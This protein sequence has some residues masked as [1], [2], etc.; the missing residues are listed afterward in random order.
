MKKFLFL[1]ALAASMGIMTSCSQEDDYAPSSGVDDN[2][3]AFSTKSND[4]MTRSGQTTNSLAKFTVTAVNADKTAHFSSVEF[5]F[6][7]F[8]S[9]FKSATPYY[10]PVGSALSFYAISNPGTVSLDA[11]NVPKYAYTN[12]GG[13]T[14]LV[15]A[16]VLAGNKQTPY[17]LA[18]QH[19]LSQIVISADAVD[20][21]EKLTYKLVDV[22]MTAPCN[23]TYSFASATGG[24]GSWEISNSA[25]KAYSYAS[26]MPKTFDQSGSASSGKVYWNILP[27]KSG[28]ITFKVAY[29]VFQN[30]KII[31]D[32]TGSKAK[33]CELVNPNLN[34]GCI[35][36][37]NFKLTRGSNDE[38]T[39]T[40]TMTGWDG[41]HT[42]T[43][44]P[45][46]NSIASYT[47]SLPCH[48]NNLSGKTI[49][50]TKAATE[51]EII[52]FLKF[53]TED[54]Y[55]C[56]IVRKNGRLEIA[57]GIDSFNTLSSTDG[58]HWTFSQWSSGGPVITSVSWE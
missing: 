58:I 57:E 55:G 12:W 16:T 32:Y 25:T 51:D 18:F 19:V 5:N 24:V 56:E 37:Y 45:V 50:L 14:D 1:A 13:E 53:G 26:A 46:S 30:G 15:A 38:I 40:T 28:T 33:T 27:V 4:V 42:G 20:K 7:S 23:G 11:N 22:E 52:Q 8:S 39:F 34:S 29:Q 6:D 17:P 48:V 41:G 10:W 47:F 9:T 35:Y 36:T 2:A 44:T 54:G 31:A 3:I 49:T 21:T 43:L